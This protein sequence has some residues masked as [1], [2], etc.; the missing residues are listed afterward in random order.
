MCPMCIS[1]V[2]WIAAGAVSTSTGGIAAVVVSKFRSQKREGNVTHDEEG[3]E[4]VKVAN[5]KGKQ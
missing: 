1:A 2:T 5:I 4:M 3:M